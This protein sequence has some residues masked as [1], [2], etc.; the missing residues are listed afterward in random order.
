MGNTEVSGYPAIPIDVCFLQ[1]SWP[2]ETYMKYECA[3]DGE[4]VNKTIYTDSGC[5]EQKGSVTTYNRSS[6]VSECGLYNFN[7][8][9]EDAF[10][11]TGVYF[12]TTKKDKKCSSLQALA[13]SAIGCFCTS[14]TSS[15]RVS[16]INDT[17]GEMIEYSDSICGEVTEVTDHS[18][19]RK[20]KSYSWGLFN[21]H[22]YSEINFCV[23]P[24]INNGSNGTIGWDLVADG[25]LDTEQTMTVVI[26]GM[27]GIVVCVLCTCCTICVCVWKRKKKKRNNLETAMSTSAEAETGKVDDGELA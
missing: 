10:M 17:V 19:C 13:P 18:Q 25:A 2:S 6:A 7:C 8:K 3:E 9:G 24:A 23:T 20:E 26:A 5:T 22:M 15:Y 16:C 12:K 21:V 14:N 4:S 1:K 27:S 11:V